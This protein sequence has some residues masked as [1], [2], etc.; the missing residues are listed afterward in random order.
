MH[1]LYTFVIVS[2]RHRPPSQG[3]PPPPPGGLTLEW[4]TTRRRAPYP[5]N[6]QQ[7]HPTQ[8]RKTRDHTDDGDIDKNPGPND[9]QE[10]ESEIGSQ[11]RVTVTRLAS[12]TE[13]ASNPHY[14]VKL[15]KYAIQALS[16]A[17]KSRHRAFTPPTTTRKHHTHT[18][19]GIGINI[20]HLRNTI[21]RGHPIT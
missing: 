6:K 7:I 2:N 19:H 5:L 18:T 12:E 8:G 16:E 15:Y 9:P 3:K 10:G 1:H 14:P 17:L 4:P 21:S 13:T 20:R 11:H